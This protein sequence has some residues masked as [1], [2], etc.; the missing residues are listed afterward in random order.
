MLFLTPNQIEEVL[1][2]IQTHQLKFISNY[3]GAD[4]L[5]NS[6][7]KQLEKAG[8]DVKSLPAISIVENAFKFGILSAAL[9]EG[10]SKKLTY[11]QFKDFLKQT[12]T[13]KLTSQEDFAL[14]QVKTRAYSDIKG[15]GNK[16]GTKFQTLLIEQNQA[17][18]DEYEK[19]IK[20]TS[21]KTIITKQSITQ[22][23]SELG[24]QT[25]DWSRD[26]GRISDFILHSAFDTG[27]A[28]KILEEYGEDSEVYKDVYPHACKHCIRLYT[29]AGVGSEPIIFKVKEL[30]LNG[31]NIGKKVEDW[32]PVIG[33]THPHCRCTVR[34]VPQG[35]SWSNETGMFS[36]PTKERKVERKSKVIIK[37]GDKIIRA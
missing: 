11:N 19:I 14:E 7:I 22:M 5:S 17:K 10:I 15:L 6:E 1:E 30:L 3:V 13:L 21:K 33:S 2:I 9:E 12:E 32:L 31:T 37:F 29:T 4:T 34:R 16:I 8:I 28:E 26:F 25:E 36:I 23:V 18:R 20:E 24:T 35:Y 27:R